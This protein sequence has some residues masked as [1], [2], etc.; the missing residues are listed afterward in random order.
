[1]TSI[2]KVD[3]IQNSAGTVIIPVM[4]G[5][6]IQ[7]KF[8]QVS[9]GTTHTS[10]SANATTVVTPLSVSITPT[11]ASSVIMIQ[12]FVTGEWSVM[13]QA[14]DSTWFF[15]RD[16][17]KLSSPAAGNRNVGIHMGTNVT[18]V[19]DEAGS[20]PENAYYS[21][22]DSPNSTSAITY[23][24]AFAGNGTATWHLNKTV[25]DSDSPNME[26]GISH[27]MVQEIAQ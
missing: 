13:G 18:Y 26:R 9:A 21:Y 11:S 6:I 1:M 16:S 20:T 10:A 8:V 14:W 27:I 25:S 19:E 15:L 23:K 5:G 2:L 12:G 17:T 4:A 7:T 3:S 24:V 22:F